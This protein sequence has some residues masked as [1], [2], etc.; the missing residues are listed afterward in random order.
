[1]CLNF[2]PED[3]V[4]SLCQF[5]L[6]YVVGRSMA[7]AC[8][9][10]HNEPFTHARLLL[11]LLLSLQGVLPVRNSFHGVVVFQRSP[12][13]FE[14]RNLLCAPTRMAVV[15]YP[16][17]HMPCCAGIAITHRCRFTTHCSTSATIL[18]WIGLKIAPALRTML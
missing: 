14:C 7:G 11:L 6:S 16:L 17:C 9:D 18:R 15:F 12:L 2:A 8:F 1:M 10:S 3:F 4:N 13:A 5:V